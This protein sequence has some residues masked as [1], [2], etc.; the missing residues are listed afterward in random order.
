MIGEGLAGGARII[1]T[2]FVVRVNRSIYFCYKFIMTVHFSFFIVHV[3]MNGSHRYKRINSLKNNNI[4]IFPFFNTQFFYLKTKNNHNLV[5]YAMVTYLNGLYYFIIYKRLTLGVHRLYKSYVLK[6]RK[7][8]NET[9][10]N[11]LL[12]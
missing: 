11:L 9:Y 10:A 8:E 2:V 1:Q 12:E 3:I 6:K 5:Q 4:F 7:I